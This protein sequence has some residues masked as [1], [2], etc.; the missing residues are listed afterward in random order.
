MPRIKEMEQVIAR[1]TRNSSNSSRP[2]SSDPPGLKKKAKTSKK[3]GKR[4]QGGQPGHKG[5]KRRLLPAEE[6]DA[7]HDIFPLNCEHCRQPLSPG[8]LDPARQPLRRQ[9]IELPP[10]I[11]VKTE[12]RLHS[13]LCPCGRHT[14]APLPEGVPDSSFGPGVH[15]AIAYLTAVH[16]VSRRGIAEI[17]TTLFGIDISTAA[18]SARLPSVFPVVSA[19]K[20]YVVSATVLNIDETGWKNKGGRCYLWCFVAPL[21]VLFHISDGRG[22]KALREILGETFAGSSAATI[23][24]PTTATTKTDAANSAGL[25]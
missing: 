21:A 19:I 17:M 11:H 15:A 1:L 5:K 25:I 18:P 23:I 4:S 10:I 6:M 16:R 20:H 2:P 14:I 9:V 12:Y 3:P 22:A 13:L 8:L 24:R 7:I